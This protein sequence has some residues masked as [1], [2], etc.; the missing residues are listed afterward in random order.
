M[1]ITSIKTKRVEQDGTESSRL[2]G[3]A[4]VVIDG[5]FIIEDIRIIKSEKKDGLFVAFPSRKQKDGG[6]KDICHPLDA[7]TRAYFEESILSDFKKSDV[8]E[9]DSSSI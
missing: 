1:I 2:L 6:Y 4:K 9:C 5:C 8:N 3:L 7:E